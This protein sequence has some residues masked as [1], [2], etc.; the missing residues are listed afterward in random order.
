ML[1][2]LRQSLKNDE[3][4][5]SFE[6]SETESRSELSRRS[7]NRPKLEP[8]EPTFG[9]A[10]TELFARQRQIKPPYETW[11]KNLP[12]FCD[13]SAF[14]GLSEGVS[15]TIRTRERDGFL[16]GYLDLLPRSFSETDARASQDGALELI[17]SYLA[18]LM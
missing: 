2:K 10:K 1:G 18:A 17:K 14:L 5:Q 16:N 3:Q 15:R 8:K 9:E 12:S 11:V 7:S 13:S 4:S 6:D